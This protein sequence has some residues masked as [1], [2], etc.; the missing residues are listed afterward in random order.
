MMK[1]MRLLSL[2]T[3]LAIGA[4]TSG[5]AANASLCYRGVNLSGGEY[6]D[7]KGVYGTNYIY[8]TEETVRYFAHSGMNAIRLPLKWERLQPELNQRLSAE[9]M[10][11]LHE[12]V[13][14][15]RK[16]GM[17][18]I[19]DPH[20][21]AQYGEDKIGAGKLAAAHLADFWGRLA[22]EFAGDDGIVFGLM[23]EPFDIEGPVW[24]D[25]ANQS[26]A[27]IRTAGARNLILVPGVIWSGAATWYHDIPGGSNASVMGGVKDPLGHYGY[28]FHQYMDGDFSGQHPTCERAGEARDAIRAVSEWLRKQGRK[29]LL[30]EFGGSSDKACVEG[31]RGM[32]RAVA[33]DAD[34]WMG[35]TYWAAGEWW[36][37]DEPLNIQPRAHQKP[38]PQ[39]RMLRAEMKA[40]P[41][42]PDRCALH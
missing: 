11:R 41:A 7:G 34:V 28:E 35:W 30:G 26:I 38:R 37:E 33:E 39:M 4:G 24:L 12:V 19:L 9:E 1:T 13:A 18:V 23:N 27:A 6:G 2:A 40:S 42:D 20:N 10:R 8:P 32:T 15:I 14:M 17:T 31:L 16:A 25:A 29:G 22:A 36:P 3:A 21:Y 5:Q